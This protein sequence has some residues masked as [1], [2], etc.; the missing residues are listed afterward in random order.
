MDDHLSGPTVAR[1][2]EHPTHSFIHINCGNETGRLLL[3]MRAC[4][5]WGL[6]CHDRH[7]S[8]G[9]LLPHL[10]TL[11]GRRLQMTPP[12]VDLGGVFSV[13]LSLGSRRV[14][15]INHRTLSSSDFPPEPQ[16]P[17]DR[18]CPLRRRDHIRQPARWRGEAWFPPTAG[19]PCPILLAVGDHSPTAC[20]GMSIPP[21]STGPVRRRLIDGGSTT[22]LT[23][24]HRPATVSRRADRS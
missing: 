8:R 21:A 5:R 9:A 4:W 7:R 6:P 2:L 15:V 18:L 14:G 24:K 16:G 11:T 3:P 20:A 1:R 23:S 17:S 10:F 12:C 19:S 22:E 13:A